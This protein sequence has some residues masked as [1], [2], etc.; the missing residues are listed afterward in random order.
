M[1]SCHVPNPVAGEV[2][3]CACSACLTARPP[4]MAI[5]WTQ[6]VASL[7]HLHT[8]LCSPRG[9][10]LNH[11]CL[12]I[13]R[14]LCIEQYNSDVWDIGIL[15]IGILGIFILVHY[16]CNYVYLHYMAS[17]GIYPGL[18]PQLVGRY[19]LKDDIRTLWTPPQTSLGGSKHKRK[20]ESSASSNISASWLGFLTHLL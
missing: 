15:L 9:W 11:V 8:S 5:H 19:M 3:Y 4:F 17:P 18:C 10:T 20:F 1:S 6:F 13:V 2:P 7:S 12:V 14:P 16:L